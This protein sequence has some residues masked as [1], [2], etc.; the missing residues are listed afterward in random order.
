MS[1]EAASAVAAESP[2]NALPTS[3]RGIL[4]RYFLNNLGALISWPDRDSR[5]HRVAQTLENLAV[6]IAERAV[7]INEISQ[8]D[9]MLRIRFGR[10]GSIQSIYD[11]EHKREVLLAGRRARK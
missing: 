4:G 8:K 3:F 10:D 11:K 6:E 7:D 5:R 2:P 1:P 9:G